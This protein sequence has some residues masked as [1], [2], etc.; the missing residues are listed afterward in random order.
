MSSDV[1]IQ[2]F[3]EINDP[4]VLSNIAAAAEVEGGFEWSEHSSQ[5]QIVE[6]AIEMAHSGEPITL[7]RNDVPTIESEMFREVRKHARSAGLSYAVVY[8]PFGDEGYDA[9]FSWRPGLTEEVRFDLG[10]DEPTV[11]ISVLKDAIAAGPDAVEAL[12]AASDEKAEVGII[13]ITPDV[14]SSFEDGALAL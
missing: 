6:Y 1:V 10:G 4:A 13:S 12:I 5:A 3:G 11:R 2:I 14:V 8:G 9:G 7:V